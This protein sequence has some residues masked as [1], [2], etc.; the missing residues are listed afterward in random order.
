MAL[1]NYCIAIGSYGQLFHPF[2]LS[3]MSSSYFEEDVPVIVEV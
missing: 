1:P 3:Q 2:S